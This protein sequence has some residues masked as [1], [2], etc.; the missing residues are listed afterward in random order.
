MGRMTLNC[1]SWT[2]NKCEPIF[3]LPPTR[4][5]RKGSGE[6]APTDYYKQRYAG[7]ALENV[8]PTGSLVKSASLV[9]SL[10]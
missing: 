8:A 3:S 5:P 10:L 6:V 7:Q 4:S 2:I 9:G 1:W